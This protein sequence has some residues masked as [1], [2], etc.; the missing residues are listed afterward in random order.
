MK[1]VPDVICICMGCDKPF[2]VR[3]CYRNRIKYC[4]S[5]CRSTRFVRRVFWTYYTV[6]DG[7]WNWIGIKDRRGYGRVK[8]KRKAVL[9]HRIAWKET[10]GPI[11]DGLCVCHKCDNP[12]C[13]NPSHLFLGTKKDNST[14]MV[15]KQRCN[16]PYGSRCWR[17][18]LTESQV[19]EIR[20]KYNHTLAHQSV[21]ASEYGVRPKA[22][23]K[24]LYRQRW[25]HI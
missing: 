15:N 16:P 19:I 11:P 20:R 5:Q 8:I 12:S 10:F 25:K 7:C 1:P 18:K 22:I 6:K 13:I 4:S 2:P 23:A 24:I 17:S 21:L 3:H 14:D 9:A